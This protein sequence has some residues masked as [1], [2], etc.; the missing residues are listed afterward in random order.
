MRRSLP[1]TAAFLLAAVRRAVSTSPA[2]S[3]PLPGVGGIDAGELG[4]A[5]AHHRVQPLVRAA[6]RHEPGT[7]H[8]L[9]A[10]DGGYWMGVT[11]HLRALTDLAAVV[12][13]FDG[14]SLRWTVFKGPVLAELVY[15]RPD[16]RLYGDV[17]ILVDPTELGAALRC[18]EGAGFRLL[19]RNWDLLRTR[20]LGELH[21]QAPAGT[22]IDLH[23]H[24]V[25]RPE[26]RFRLRL[27]T[28]A[29][30][31]RS[32]PAQIAGVRVPV[33]DRVDA[34]VHL[35]VHA[36]LGGGD[37]LL[38]LTDVALAMER[39]D[40]IDLLAARA[41]D[42]GGTSQ[43]A[44]MLSRA[45]AVQASPRGEAALARLVPDRSARRMLAAADALFPVA[46]ATPGRSVPRFVALATGSTALDT[47]QR[48]ARGVRRRTT[49]RQRRADSVPL[50]SPDNPASVLYA[51]GG[52]AAREEFLQRVAAQGRLV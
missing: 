25:N 36:C 26:N 5:A 17:D 7:D 34:V 51:S 9:P 52:P 46:A 50:T 48:V 21:L 1:P 18:L 47:A 27:D 43:L 6:I 12:S 42:M 31:A 20:M 19:D 44:L 41:A 33:L 16:L 39:V 3:T 11:T 24:M 10:V 4:V 30:L 35:A 45:R 14:T 22:I 15:P 23:W 28:S 8:L 32:V 2:P 13:A 38:W 40:D 37:R 29:L 49:P